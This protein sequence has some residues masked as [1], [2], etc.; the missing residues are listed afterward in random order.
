M[1]EKFVMYTALIMRLM[2]YGSYCR[3]GGRSTH[4]LIFPFDPDG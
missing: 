2:V 3:V 1:I 4:L